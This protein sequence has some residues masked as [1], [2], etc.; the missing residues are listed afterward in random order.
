MIY[1]V[2][3]AGEVSQRNS[4]QKL[5]ILNPSFYRFILTEERRKRIFVISSSQEPSDCNYRC[6]GVVVVRGWPVSG[7]FE[8]VP[9]VSR[10]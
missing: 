10:G 2:C 4:G 1:C 3:W 5:T 7:D 6:A 8:S 9:V